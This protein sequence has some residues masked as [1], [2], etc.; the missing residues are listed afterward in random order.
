MAAAG[1]GTSDSRRLLKLSA[2]AATVFG[3][4]GGQARFQQFPLRNDHE[5][6]PSSDL[7]P[8]EHISN[9]SFSP[10]TLNGATQLAGG[11]NAQATDFE[12]VPA[13]K[14]RCQTAV[15]FGALFIDSLEV[16]APADPFLR[17]ECQQTTR[18]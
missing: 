9:Q 17:A 2:E 1:E 14:Q 8:P 3:F 12:P 13:N 5:V 11:S 4:N 7:V 6:Q 18:C 15:D 16:S 10:I